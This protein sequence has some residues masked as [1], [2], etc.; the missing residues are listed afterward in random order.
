MGY[1][2]ARKDAQIASDEIDY[3]RRQL[4]IGGST[5]ANVLSAEAKLYEAEAAETNFLSENKIT[6][7]SVSYWSIVT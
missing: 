3:L 7:E 1:E 2:L 5:L 4:V 6:T